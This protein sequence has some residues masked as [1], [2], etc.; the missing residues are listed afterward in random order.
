[1][2]FNKNRDQRLVKRRSPK[3]EKKSLLPSYKNKMN[4]KMTRNKKLII[5]K[6]MT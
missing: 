2:F 4:A 3:R 1:M 5:K 6:I